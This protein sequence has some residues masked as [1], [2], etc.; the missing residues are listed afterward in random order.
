M[1]CSLFCTH[2]CVPLWVLIPK[3]KESNGNTSVLTSVLV[4]IGELAQVSGP[5]MAVYS[6]NLIS[7]IIDMLQVCLVC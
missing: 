5:E 6:D 2:V 3:L 4:A 7:I 1:V